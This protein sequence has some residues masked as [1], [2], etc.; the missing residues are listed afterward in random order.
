MIFTNKA[1][2]RVTKILH[3][4]K[5]CFARQQKVCILSAFAIF[6]GS[7]LKIFAPLKRKVFFS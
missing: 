1:K 7:S 3:D 4:K 5:K 6:E 2:R